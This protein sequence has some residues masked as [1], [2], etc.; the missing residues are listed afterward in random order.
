M[1]LGLGDMYLFRERYD[2]SSEIVVLEDRQVVVLPYRSVLLY[3]TP[4][5]YSDYTTSSTE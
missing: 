1:W 5:H 4:W 2:E 3:K